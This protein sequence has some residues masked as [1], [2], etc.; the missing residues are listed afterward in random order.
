MGAVESAVQSVLSPV[1]DVAKP[2]LDPL[3]DIA[4]KPLEAVLPESEEAFKLARSLLGTGSEGKSPDA[5]LLDKL[6]SSVQDPL[7]Q[8]MAHVDNL[9]STKPARKQERMMRAI[10]LFLDALEAED[11]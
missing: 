9:S 4:E 1:L 10:E 11:L 8:A 2:V 5:V 3:I 6:P 7:R